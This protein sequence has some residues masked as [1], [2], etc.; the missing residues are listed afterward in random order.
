MMAC[1]FLAASS[2]EYYFFDFCEDPD[3]LEYVKEFHSFKTVPVVLVNDCETG[4]TFKI[5]GYEDLL[6]W[7]NL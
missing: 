1:D 3:F 2:E 7:A 6:D 5:G 4:K